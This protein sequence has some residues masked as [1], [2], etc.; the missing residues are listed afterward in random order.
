MS[1][2]NL[3]R[4]LGLS[5]LL[6]FSIVCMA[7]ESSTK[8]AAATQRYQATRL[9]DSLPI[10][11]EEMFV[12][13]GASEYEGHNMNGPSVIRI[14]DWIAPENRANPDARYY[15]YFA[16]HSDAY[17]RMAW[18]ADIEGPWHLYDVGT[19]VDIGDRGV[20]DHGGESIVL[21]NGL[22]IDPN[23]L[24]SP[25][26]HVDYE[27]QRIILYF[28]SGS[29][30]WH[31]GVEIDKQISWVA[32]SP[33]GLE[34][35]NNIEPVYLGSS[36]FAV[37]EYGGEMYALDNGASI[38]KALDA[39][40]PWTPPADHNFTKGLWDKRSDNPFQEAITEN[41]GLPS[42]DLRVRHASVRVVGDTLHVF[43]S[44]RGDLLENIQMSAV[45]M[46]AGDWKEWVCP[47]PPEQILESLP[48]WEGGEL[49]PAYSEAGPAPEDVNQLRDPYVFVDTDDSLY[50]FYT[51]RGEDAIGVARLS[52]VYITYSLPPDDPTSLL[53]DPVSSSEI[54][55]QWSDNSLNEDGFKL[56]RKSGDGEYEDIGKLSSNTTS[57]IDQG[58]S[59]ST[60]FTYRVYAYNAEGN[61]AYTNEASATTFNNNSETFTYGA[62]EDTYVRGGE[63]ANL[64][65]GSDVEL[66]LKTGSKEDFFRRVLVKFDMRDK[67]LG[68]NDIA[69][70]KLRLYAYR[71]STSVIAASEIDD[72]WTENVVTWATAPVSRKSISTAEVSTADRYYEWN[73]TA[74]VQSKL[75][76][77]SVISICVEDLI[78]ANANVE[79]NSREANSNRPELV[80]NTTGIPDPTSSSVAENPL[81]NVYPNPAK[82]ILNVNVSNDRI[83][84][85][86][87]YDLA[88]QAVYNLSDLHGQSQI[89]IG[90]LSNGIYLLKVETDS[91]ISIA[92][93]IKSH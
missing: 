55:L 89:N 25:D 85:L 52:E 41:T 31:N 53:A 5:L 58:L 62:N 1:C 44:R 87:I 65:F 39:N 7:Q 68:S 37:F 42:G 4:V 28:H 69:R 35:Y 82:D 19:G 54:E 14:P 64:N 13:L 30:S 12:D 88:G 60:T 22:S 84:N 26:A 32:T 10:I 48:G 45:D 43:Y 73:V 93:F 9:N 40:D 33:Y 61:S 21:G 51:G 67:E 3:R 76:L 29:S 56:E 24:A 15:C 8:G 49:P 91:G 6:I 36:Y 57:Y 90:H 2:S 71:A 70:A 20:L 38:Y 18:A 34:F 46:S 47:W 92:K 80:I 72:L 11:Y 78:A 75:S 66:Q 79:F 59:D 50:V 83:R 27:N 77:D 23:H 63:S 16:H 86:L 74:Y 81:I 17:I